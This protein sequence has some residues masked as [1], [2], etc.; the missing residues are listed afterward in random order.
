VSQRRCEACLDGLGFRWDEDCRFLIRSELNAVFFH[1]YL[2]ADANGIGRLEIG[3]VGKIL[4]QAEEHKEN[5]R[6]A[7]RG[8]SAVEIR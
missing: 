2:P 4:G 1:L 5:S 8:L 7:S 3:L 6:L